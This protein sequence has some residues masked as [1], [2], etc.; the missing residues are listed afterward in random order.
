MRWLWLAGAVALVPTPAA[1]QLYW[2]D[3]ALAGAP[4]VGGEPGLGLA[5]P[6]AT[7]AEHQA[8]LVWNLRAALNVAALSCHPWP[9][10]DTIDNYNQM[11]N[12]HGGEL[13]PAYDTLQKYFTRRL[14]QRPG[15]K[16][17]DDYNTKTYNGFST[18][19]AKLSFCQVVGDVGKQ[20]RFAPRGGLTAIAQTR[21]R[22]VRNSLTP[23]SDMFFA[24]PG[25]GQVAVN[26]LYGGRR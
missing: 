21:M 6:D 16:A 14:G 18:L 11:L 10:L 26:G 1:A 7:A 23:V 19:Y 13:R 22:E 17:F 9:I 12:D 4:V 8:A 20:V 5:M 2:K 24:V 15:M 25:L 3:P